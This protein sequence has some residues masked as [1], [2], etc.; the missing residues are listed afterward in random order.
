MLG[1]SEIDRAETE[2]GTSA[3]TVGSSKKGRGK[4]ADRLESAN[5][6]IFRALRLSLTVLFPWPW[7]D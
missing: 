5:A 6:N 7:D 4:V 3:S 1:H 2:A